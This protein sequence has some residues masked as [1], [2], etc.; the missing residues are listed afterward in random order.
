MGAEIPHWVEK[1]DWSKKAIPGPDGQE[2][3]ANLTAVWLAQYGA[4][5]GWIPVDKTDKAKELARARRPVDA[6]RLAQEWANEGKPVVAVFY[7][8]GGIGHVAMVIPS[9]EPYDPERGPAI[10]QAGET[11]MN[12]GYLKDGF[13]R[14]RMGAVI[15]YVHE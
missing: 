13:G 7:N 2:L 9:D 1:R 11:N 5:N 3:D 8:P 14:Q 15:Y 12:R 10:A 6:G 4:S